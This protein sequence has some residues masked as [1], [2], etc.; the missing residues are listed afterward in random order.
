METNVSHSILR[1]SFL[2]YVP[3]AL[4]TLVA[5]RSL[6]APR[7]EQNTNQN[8]GNG[9]PPVHSPPP[10]PNNGQ[11]NIPNGGGSGG[12]LAQQGGDTQ[13]PQKVIPPSDPAKTKKNDPKK[14]LRAD[15]RDIR[16]QVRQLAEY[17]SEL[18]QEIDKID[19]TK[20][21]SVDIIRKTQ[22]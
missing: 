10:F 5:A 8:G 1:R 21:L 15:E 22:D 11:G 19:S 20:V 18:K 14:D 3:G 13:A 17:A 6:A 12:S 9:G 2:G 16:D 7:M 4:L